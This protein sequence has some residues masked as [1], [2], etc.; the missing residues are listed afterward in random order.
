[1]GPGLEMMQPG[2][3]NDNR[4]VCTGRGDLWPVEA[5]L[6]RSRLDQKKHWIRRQYLGTRMNTKR[7]MHTAAWD[8]E[9]RGV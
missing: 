7:K 3:I 4:S 9:H 2:S 8:A 5:N 6:E 1:M